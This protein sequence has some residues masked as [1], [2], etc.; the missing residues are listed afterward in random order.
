VVHVD[1]WVLNV[2]AN[3]MASD[4]PITVRDIFFYPV[5]V[6]TGERL[7]S[8]QNRFGDATNI[9]TV[10]CNSRQVAKR[11]LTDAFGRATIEK[12]FDAFMG[13]I[14]GGQPKVIEGVGGHVLSDHASPMLSIINLASVKDLER[15][16]QKSVNSRRFRGNILIN[17]LAPWQEFDWIRKSVAI[18]DVYFSVTGRIDRCAA[19]NVNPDTAEREMNIVASLKRG[20]DHIDMGVFIRVETAGTI[21]AG[22][23]LTPPT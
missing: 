16:T 3:V 10:F 21:K 1:S 6:L 5:K 22:A 18:A 9:L 20:F 7:A 4:E 14:S 15:V 8:I 23:Y 11:K 13:K 17:G 2:I 19:T 12:N